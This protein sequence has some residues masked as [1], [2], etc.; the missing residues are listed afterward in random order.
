MSIDCGGR[1]AS[2]RAS[3][4]RG[5]GGLLMREAEEDKE[6]EKEGGKEEKRERGRVLLGKYGGCA[7]R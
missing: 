2:P 7:G 1:V 6:S 3:G 5:D 4:I